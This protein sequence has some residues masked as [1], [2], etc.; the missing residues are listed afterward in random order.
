F[1]EANDPQDKERIRRNVDW[2]I[3][4]R[5]MDN[6][7]LQ[8]WGYTEDG[9]T[10]DNSNSQY[11]LLGLHA[12][13]MAGIPI[14]IAVWRSIGE[15]YVNTQA[16]GPGEEGGWG[17]RLGMSSIQ[18]MTIAGLCGLQIV[19]LELNKS[20]QGLRPDGTAERCGIY[21]ENEAIEKALAWL[22]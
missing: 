3:K 22:A 12:G 20:R 15:Y 2:L 14:D 16:Q 6:G 11:A 10:L 18:T 1:A 9:G 17:Y 5:K 4:A 21:P 13:R 8:G 19:A 7:R